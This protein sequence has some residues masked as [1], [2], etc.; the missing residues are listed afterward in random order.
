MLQQPKHHARFTSTGTYDVQN[1][2]YD[3]Q[4]EPFTVAIDYIENTG[5]LGAL[6]ALMY[7]DQEGNIV[8]TAIRRSKAPSQWVTQP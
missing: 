8:Y 5:A 2:T 4:D 6:L 7:L 3:I 1:T